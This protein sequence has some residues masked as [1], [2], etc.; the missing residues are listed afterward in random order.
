VPPQTESIIKA[1]QESIQPKQEGNA[2]VVNEVPNKI[3]EEEKQKKKK[4]NSNRKK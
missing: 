4:K 3:E 2:S 1:Q